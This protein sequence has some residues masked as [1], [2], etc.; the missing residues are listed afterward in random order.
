[1]TNLWNEKRPSQLVSLS[2]Q[3]YFPTWSRN[4]SRN[5]SSE[6]ESQSSGTGG[7]SILKS[8]PSLTANAGLITISSSTGWSS[9]G[10]LTESRFSSTGT[11]RIGDLMISLCST[12]LHSKTPKVR[13][14]IRTP[15][16]SKSVRE[17]R[18]KLRKFLPSSMS[19][20]NSSEL[21]SEKTDCVLGSPSSS[22]SLSLWPSSECGCVIAD[23]PSDSFVSSGASG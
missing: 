6:T 7:N 4:P 5:F 18:Y 10:S 14:R 8:S 12:S 19:V 3:P 16:S 22:G 23:L 21:R 20:N 9:K 15:R 17:R 2:V 1:M 11:S 13:N